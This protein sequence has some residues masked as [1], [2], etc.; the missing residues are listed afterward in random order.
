MGYMPQYGDMSNQQVMDHLQQQNPD[1]MQ[2][3][4]EMNDPEGQEDEE[5][6]CLHQ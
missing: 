5:G 3:Q 4:M 2:Q 6:K 1:E